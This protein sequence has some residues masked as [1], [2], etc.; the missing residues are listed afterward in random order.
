M[1]P[2]PM[3]AD[4]GRR[5]QREH[6]QDREDETDAGRHADQ[7]RHPSVD[8]P[9]H[10]LTPGAERHPNADLARPLRDRERDDRIETDA[11]STRARP[12]RTPRHVATT[13]G[14]ACDR[15]R[16]C[17][18]V[19]AVISGSV[20]S[21]ARSSRCIAPRRAAASPYGRAMTVAGTR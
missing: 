4:P 1:L 5:A 2:I 21:T 12:P 13:F 19:C 6:D 14:A 9:D 7:P 16:S 20:T 17:A 8:A 15:S 11:R 3:S 18:I 10:L